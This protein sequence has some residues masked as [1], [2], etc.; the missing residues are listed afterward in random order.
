MVARRAVFAALATR[1]TSSRSAF[2]SSVQMVPGEEVNEENGE[3][4]EGE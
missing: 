3:G 1:R 2:S 4:I